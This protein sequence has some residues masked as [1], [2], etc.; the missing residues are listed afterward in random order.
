VKKIGSLTV[1]VACQLSNQSLWRATNFRTE[2]KALFQNRFE[3]LDVFLL[4]TTFELQ[5]Y[6]S[7]CLGG[8]FCDLIII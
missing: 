3:L 5:V 8:V 4:E 6:S 2:Q 7:G 1:L